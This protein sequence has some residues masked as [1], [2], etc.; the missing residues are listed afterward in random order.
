MS[1]VFQMQP[2]VAVI[3]TRNSSARSIVTDLKGVGA[4]RKDAS[5]KNTGRAVEIE[6]TVVPVSP[7]SQNSRPSVKRFVLRDGFIPAS[8]TK[9]NR[10]I[11]VYSP[12]GQLLGTI[13]ASAV[14]TRGVVKNPL[15]T[16]HG[17]LILEARDSD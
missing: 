6:N 16:G 17:V 1:T 2:R 5:A 15:L 13:R 12:R 14:D 9:A 10:A 4:M 11:A 3:A 8:L 7:V